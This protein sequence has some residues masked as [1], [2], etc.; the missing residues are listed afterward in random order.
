[1]DL[2]SF[3]MWHR[4]DYQPYCNNFIQWVLS[5]MGNGN[6]HV[7][8]NGSIYGKVNRNGRHDDGCGR[9]WVEVRDNGRP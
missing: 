5:V 6:W 2:N 9:P 3:I 7:R 8:G 1:M 4:R